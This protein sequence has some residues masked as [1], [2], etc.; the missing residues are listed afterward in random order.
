MVGHPRRAP[1][2]TSQTEPSKGV[3]GDRGQEP[4]ASLTKLQADSPAKATDE[5]GVTR[6]RGPDTPPGPGPG[7]HARGAGPGRWHPGDVA[8]TALAFPEAQAPMEIQALK[9]YFL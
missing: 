8:G 6:N 9:K 4:L 7:D 1:R 3:C 2:P 5:H